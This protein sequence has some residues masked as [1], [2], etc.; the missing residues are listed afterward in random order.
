MIVGHIG[1]LN[2]REGV[3]IGVK[4]PTDYFDLT[5]EYLNIS[6][7]QQDSFRIF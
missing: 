5:E 2:N 3:T 6:L 1:L 7:Q 4:F